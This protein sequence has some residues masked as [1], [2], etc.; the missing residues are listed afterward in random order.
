MKLQLSTLFLLGSAIMLQAA[1]PQVGSA[2]NDKDY[3]LVWQDLFD[4]TELNRNR[5]NVE[6]NGDGG[7]NNELQYYIDSPETVRVGDDGR[8]TVASLSLQYVRATMARVLS[9]AA[10][11]AATSLILPMARLRPQSSFPIQP[12]ACGPHFG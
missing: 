2:A 1:E 7:G 3:K 11:T 10:S 5:W 4:G 9:Q 8:V 12:T 6:V